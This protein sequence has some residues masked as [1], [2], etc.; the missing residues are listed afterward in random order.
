M[1]DIHRSSHNEKKT[2]TEQA[3]LFLYC[4]IYLIMNMYLY[5]SIY[6]QEKK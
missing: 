3:F 2:D 5:F 1:I 6:K 4:I